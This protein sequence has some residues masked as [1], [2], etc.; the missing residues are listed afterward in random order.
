MASESKANGTAEMGLAEQFALHPELDEPEEFLGG[1]VQPR[2]VEAEGR[3]APPVPG[4]RA[5][6]G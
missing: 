2:G 5:K 3:R 4:E 6:G 1:P